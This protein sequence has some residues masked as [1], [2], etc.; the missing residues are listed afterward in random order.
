M[1]ELLLL[2]RALLFVLVVVASGCTRIPALPTASKA[3]R[4]AATCALQ[5]LPSPISFVSEDTREAVRAFESHTGDLFAA[6]YIK[7]AAGRPDQDV[8]VRVVQQAADYFVRYTYRHGQLDSSR[9][10][11][12]TWAPLLA[13]LD[14]G[15]YTAHC[16]SY[17]TDPVFYLL[18]VKHN[19]RGLFSLCLETWQHGEFSAADSAR[20]APARGLIQQLT[21]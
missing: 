15:N 6:L 1:P 16:R 7:R 20:I 19:T 12:S 2:R 11:R 9:I 18:L 8:C 14:T 4:A 13:R 10:R 5:A 21:N 3:P 17:T